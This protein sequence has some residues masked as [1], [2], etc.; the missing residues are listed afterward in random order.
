MRT[1]TRLPSGSW[2]SGAQY[3]PTVD[4]DGVRSAVIGCPKC[5]LMGHLK[6]SHQIA[7]DGTVSPSVV[8]TTEGCGFHEFIRLEGWAS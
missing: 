6:G 8:C 5:G 2:P 3:R 7:D 4:K 1:F